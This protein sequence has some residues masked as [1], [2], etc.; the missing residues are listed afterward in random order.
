M[1]INSHAMHISGAVQQQQLSMLQEEEVPAP[2]EGD[3]T[4]TK[5]TTPVLNLALMAVNPI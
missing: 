1:V 3:S 4:S 5:S 2:V